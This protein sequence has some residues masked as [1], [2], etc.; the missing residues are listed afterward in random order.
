MPL[1]KVQTPL[2]RGESVTGCRLSDA[3]GGLV[4]D[5][6]ITAD[7][8]GHLVVWI[9]TGDEPAEI[10]GFQVRL[11]DSTV[12]ANPPEIEAAPA[13]GEPTSKSQQTPAT[14]EHP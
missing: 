5:V 8:D 14:Q 4:V 13:R 10:P 9:D 11:N 6:V 2:R 12:F 3:E 7:V 1:S